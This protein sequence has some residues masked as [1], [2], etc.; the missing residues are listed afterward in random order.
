MATPRSH[1]KRGGLRASE[2]KIKSGI[3]LIV[4]NFLTKKGKQRD[5]ETDIEDLLKSPKKPAVSMTKTG[6]WEDRSLDI[7]MS[8]RASSHL[9]ARHFKQRENSRD[10]R[11][12]SPRSLQRGQDME[13]DLLKQGSDLR[14]KVSMDT[15]DDRDS[16]KA[17]N[18]LSLRS[19]WF[20]FEDAGPFV[21]P[22][23]M[24]DMYR[25]ETSSFG[26]DFTRASPSRSTRVNSNLQSDFNPNQRKTSRRIETRLLSK[27]SKIADESLLCQLLDSV[28]ARYQR[29][30]FD[31]LYSSDEHGRNLKLLY[32]KV[33]KKPNTLL[34]IQ[35]D[36]GSVFGGYASREWISQLHFYGNSESFLFKLQPKVEIFRSTNK[37]EFFQLC[38]GNSLAMGG[39]K[40]CGFGLILDNSLIKGH[41]APCETFGNDCLAEST[42]FEIKRIEVWTLTN[43]SGKDTD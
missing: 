6:E 35:D 42:E 22:R 39:G 15:I 17:K 5:V 34:L 19:D 2:I 36:V 11:M 28:P 9:N 14:S 43:R 13:S 27:P 33:S 32:K 37:N 41:S 25:S 20:N 21:R 1:R 40:E 16:L 38:N 3:A 12:R 30:T 23:T 4:E 24:S 8:P 10:K 18:P 7:P 29:S 26:V 31:L